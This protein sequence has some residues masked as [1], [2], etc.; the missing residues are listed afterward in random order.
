MI[1]GANGVCAQARTGA[2]SL[3]TLD[4][5]IGLAIVLIAFLALVTR[6]ERYASRL[7][8]CALIVV[9]ALATPGWWALVAQRA[10]A[11]ARIGDSARQ[12]DAL[13]ISVA[14]FAAVRGCVE[15]TRDDCVA[16]E[17]IVRL[18][19]AGY[20]PCASPPSRVVV[21]AVDA[22]ATPCVGNANLLV[23]GHSSAAMSGP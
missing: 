9:L 12:I 4:A 3:A 7:R 18:A 1:D 6:H 19:T 17:P 11:P 23:C 2:R 14:R 5:A 10:D 20:R 16:C 21:L 15:V 22:F 13:G 8:V